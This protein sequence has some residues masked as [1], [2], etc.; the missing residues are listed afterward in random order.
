MPLITMKL[1]MSQIKLE[2]LVRCTH[3]HT[4]TQLFTSDLHALL[5]SDM[6]S[7]QL[8]LFLLLLPSLERE[9]L[10]NGIMSRANSDLL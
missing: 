7:L 3:T 5:F 8:V 10:D 2:K 6:S 4:H 1:P 9:K